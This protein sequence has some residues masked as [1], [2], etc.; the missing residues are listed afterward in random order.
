[1]LSKIYL[2][3][4]ASPMAELDKQLRVVNALYQN[5]TINNLERDHKKTALIKQ[6]LALTEHGRWAIPSGQEGACLLDGNRE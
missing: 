1:M 2:S 6:P 5:N 3:K 4:A